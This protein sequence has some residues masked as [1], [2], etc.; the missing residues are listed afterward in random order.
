M[1]NN[2]K[3]N[4]M[5]ESNWVQLES[6][7]DTF[8]IKLTHLS[9]LTVILAPLTGTLKILAGTIQ[10]VA[11]TIFKLIFSLAARLNKDDEFANCLKEHSRQH[12][13]HGFGNIMAGLIESI[14]I[15][16][17]IALGIRYSRKPSSVFGM[18]HTSHDWIKNMPYQ[19]VAKRRLEITIE[20]CANECNE[21]ALR[22]AKHFFKFA[23]PT[24]E[25]RDKASLATMKADALLSVVMAEI[26]HNIKALIKPNPEEV[27][28]QF[29]EN[30][31]FE[32]VKLN[33]KG[34]RKDRLS[35]KLYDIILIK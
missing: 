29:N 32:A 10:V 33:P 27:V 23:Y 31:G 16:S 35:G 3:N 30:R 20:G 7:L 17:S 15:I 18:Y 4:L 13:R 6:A 8:E 19:S 24:A 11:G 12:I 14:P 28:R 26:N 22:N 21:N 9:G 2:L 25:S 34:K 1:I 5:N